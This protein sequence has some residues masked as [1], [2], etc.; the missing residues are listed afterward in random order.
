RTRQGA[1]AETDP[2]TPLA[3]PRPARG[4]PRRRPATADAAGD[5]RLELRLA[6]R[7]RA[8]CRP[9]HLDL[10]RRLH[11]GRRR[12]GLRRWHQHAA[13]AGRE[14]PAPFLE[15]A[16]LD[17]RDDSRVCARLDA[18]GET[19]ALARRHADYHLA[20]LEER[21]PLLLGSRRRELLA[22][23][24]E[25]EDNLRATLDYLERAAPPDAARAA[26]LLT[27]FSLPRG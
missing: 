17:A 21:R 16:L 8:T 26:T 11:P 25:E 2:R 18:A 3:A 6:L 4:W 9:R 10:R 27:P 24:E 19:E 12:R 1:F 23:F 22:W 7:G 14:E 20:L 5:D 13:V 15:R